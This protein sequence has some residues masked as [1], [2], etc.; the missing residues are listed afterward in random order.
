MI[1]GR[2]LPHFFRATAPVPDR[3]Y[4]VGILRPKQVGPDVNATTRFRSIAQRA[5]LFGV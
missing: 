2:F 3:L 5:L 1:E 4:H